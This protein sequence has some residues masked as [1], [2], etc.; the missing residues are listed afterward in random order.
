MMVGIVGRKKDTGNYEAF[1][2]RHKVPYMTSLS[3][4]DLAACE[5]L[6]FPGGGDITPAF[7]G[8][9]DRG[10]RSIDTE[11]DILQFDILSRF[12]A[13]KKP[14]LGIC[15]GLQLINIHFG[16]DITQHIDTAEIHRWIGRDQF[17]YVF[18]GSLGRRDFFYRLY[19]SSIKVNSAH[20]QAV[21][22]IGEGLVP[23][24]RAGDNV[25]EGLAHTTLPVLAVQWHPER[26]PDAGGESLFS[27][28]LSLR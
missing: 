2:D 8:E 9:R 19:G 6:I 13:Q 21:N 1:L 22:R 23:V 14:V 11:L 15:K 26:L 10:S 20:H 3:I 28:F 7:F 4:S 17:H 5:S 12:T 25:I 18:H 16:G 27:Y 24:C